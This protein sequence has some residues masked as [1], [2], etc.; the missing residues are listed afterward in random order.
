MRD[1]IF[2]YMPLLPT[3][4]YVYVE[5]YKPPHVLKFGFP[6]PVPYFLSDMIYG[7]ERGFSCFH[8]LL[9]LGL[10][11]CNGILCA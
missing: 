8:H 9:R 4:V 6:P 1:D 10:G 7:Q 11:L 5:L 3:P 2:Q